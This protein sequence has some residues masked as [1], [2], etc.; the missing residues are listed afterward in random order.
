MDNKILESI[1]GQQALST[2]EFWRA[3][4]IVFNHYL[5]WEFST[6]FPLSHPRRPPEEVVKAVELFGCWRDIAFE[7]NW[8]GYED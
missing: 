2:R 4:L 8:P 1:A 5:V 6:F 3:F 7:E